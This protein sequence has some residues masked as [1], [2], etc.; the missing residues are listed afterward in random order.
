MSDVVIVLGSA[1]DAKFLKDAAITTPL[2]AV[3]VSYAIAV[4]S[5]HRNSAQLHAYAQE[6]IKAGAKVFIGVAGMAAALPGALAGGTGMTKPVIGVPLDEHGIDSCLYM[7]P[8]V[9]VLLTGVGKVG[10][11]NAALAALQI[12]ATGDPKVA[13]ALGEYVAQT[14]KSPQYGLNLDE[15]T[16]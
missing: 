1:S 15:V 11:K 14:N 7:P 13:T 4:V 12:L 9:P 2:E 3:N 5:A 6:Q 8:G 16:A 10:L